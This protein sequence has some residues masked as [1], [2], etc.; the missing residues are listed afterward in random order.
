MRTVGASVV[1]SFEKSITDLANRKE[2]SVGWLAGRLLLRGWIEFL[3]DGE[4]E[5]EGVLNQAA[6]RGLP[7]DDLDLVAAQLKIERDSKDL[8]DTRGVA[9]GAGRDIHQKKAKKG[10]K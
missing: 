10:V 7:Q 4:L 8:A 1:A 6:T 3:A 5:A 2:R 9:S